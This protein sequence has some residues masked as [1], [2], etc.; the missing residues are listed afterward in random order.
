[1]HK[2]EIINTNFEGNYKKPLMKKILL[3][4]FTL[5]SHIYFAQ[6]WL[7][8]GV[9]SDFANGQTVQGHTLAFYNNEPYVVYY[10]STY[11]GFS[12]KRY[13][14][15]N[16]V[17]L[18]ILQSM[19]Q[20]PVGDYHVE[21]IFDQAG[22]LYVVIYDG[23]AEF[24]IQYWDPI[25]GWNIP[26]GTPNLYDLEWYSIAADTAGGPYIAYQSNLG[27]NAVIHYPKGSTTWTTVGS[28]NISNNEA[29]YIKL[30]IDKSGTPYVGYD[31]FNTVNTTYT[32]TVQK[33][34]GSNWVN[35]GTP[36]FS[37]NT[38]GLYDLEIDSLDKLYMVH[39]NDLL[40]YNGSSWVSISANMPSSSPCNCLYDAYHIS[41]GGNAYY[42]V[43]HLSPSPPQLEVFEKVSNTWPMLGSGITISA[44]NYM[45]V[46]TNNQGVPYIFYC[47]GVQ[48]H[49]VKLGSSFGVE[50]Y[51]A[52][53]IEVYPNPGNGELFLKSNK[54]ITRVEISNVLGDVVHF[55]NEKF[56]SKILNI[57]L[58]GGT[59]YLSLTDREGMVVRKT[60]IRQ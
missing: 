32:T 19:M 29:S 38:F 26:N 3:I 33:F 15:G 9:P 2:H 5:F 56:F 50:Q 52:N 31:D 44:A 37:G 40:K 30:V 47:D 20:Q 57:Q 12:V 55:D 6:S 1:M 58:P 23:Q 48:P 7:Q 4:A 17:D 46:A 54:E 21:M 11:M 28:G 39:Q 42:A 27:G 13:T 49:V 18:G 22:I 60:I 24:T 43:N 35:V 34:N 14:G 53:V 45:S 10:D 36:P 51:N 41:K 59:Y 16:W 25:N 8:V